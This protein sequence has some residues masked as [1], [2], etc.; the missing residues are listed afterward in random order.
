MVSIYIIVNTING[1]SY[2]GKTGKS[3]T[4]RWREH[5]NIARLG[6]RRYLSSAIRKYGPEAFEMWEI[7]R[8]E[9]HEAASLKEMKWIAILRTYKREQGY[10]LTLGGDGAVGRKNSPETNA[11]LSA[12]Q[13]RRWKDPDAR[14]K[15]SRS[16]KQ[17]FSD[18]KY[19]AERS[20]RVKRQWSDPM[21]RAKMM[22]AHQKSK[23]DKCFVPK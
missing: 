11:R 21:F 8:A 13:T 6:T 23:I 10:N 9:T 4:S 19:H 2:V 15:Q 20:A 17:T 18:P 3:L 22:L 12:A 5:I 1:K 16:L 7:D 14:G